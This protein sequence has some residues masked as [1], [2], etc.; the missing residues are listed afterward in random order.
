MDNRTEICDDIPTKVVMRNTGI[1][2]EGAD[3]SGKSTLA[4]RLS[5]LVGGGQVFHYSPP[6]GVTDFEHEYTRFLDGA[7]GPAGSG[8]TIVDRC[9]LSEMVYGP[10]FRGAS[11]VTPEVQAAIEERLRRE[12]YVVVLVHREDFGAHNFQQ[13]NELYDFDG[14]MR[15]RESFL[16]KF[17]SVGL[18]KVVIDAFDWPWCVWD[19]V[20]LCRRAWRDGWKA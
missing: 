12:R 8:K 16:E 1:I 17:E 6:K 7:T 5:M 4:T 11:G 20:D 15:V 14:I 19:V 13:R 9:Y 2:L 18:P 3:Q 10:M